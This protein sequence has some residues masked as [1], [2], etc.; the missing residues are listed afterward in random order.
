MIALTKPQTLIHQMDHMK[1]QIQFHYGFHF[2]PPYLSC[3]RFY[4]DARNFSCCT[5]SECNKLGCTL[6]CAAVFEITLAYRSA[7]TLFAQIY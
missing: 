2:K 1:A 5:D 7:F 6:Q 4:L 3:F